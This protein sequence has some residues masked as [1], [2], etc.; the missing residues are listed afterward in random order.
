MTDERSDLKRTQERGS[1]MLK[2]EETRWALA[3]KFDDKEH[4]LGRY[5]WDIHFAETIPT[6]KTRAEARAMKLRLTSYLDI[7]R[8]VKVRVTVEAVKGKP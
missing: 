2:H 7:A 6:F 3:E 4:F 8:V 1:M 5:C